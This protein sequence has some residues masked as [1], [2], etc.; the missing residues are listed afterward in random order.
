MYLNNIIKNNKKKNNSKRLTS[1]R[2]GGV[3]IINFIGGYIELRSCF[4]IMVEFGW[5]F[6][7]I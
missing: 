5:Y 4:I 3:D 7:F 2:E 6:R 1:N